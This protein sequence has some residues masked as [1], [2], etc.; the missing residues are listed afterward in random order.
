VNMETLAVEHRPNGILIVTLNRAEKRNALDDE[1]VLGLEQLFGAIPHNVRVVVLRGAGD[2]FCA[3][4]DLNSLADQD[5]Q[6]RIARSKLW[7]RAFEKIEFGQAPVITAMHGAVIGGGLELACAT[8]IR[9][10]D[11]SVFYGL[12]EGQRGIYLGGGGSVRLPRLIGLPR[13]MDMMLTGRVYDAEAGHSIGLCQ[14][15]VGA[16]KA[17][18]KAL[19]LAEAVAKNAPLTNFGVTHALPRIARGDPDSGY[20]TEAL[21]SALAQEAPEAQQRIDSFLAGRSP[22]DRKL[23][24]SDTTPI[25]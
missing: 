11:S 3:G 13:M 20:L 4:L 10:S 16:G 5:V 25:R 2:H 19:E 15:L 6:K 22:Q 17:F 12:P 14:Y 18:D 21:M 1:T 9:V 8:H 23:T 24:G 7:S